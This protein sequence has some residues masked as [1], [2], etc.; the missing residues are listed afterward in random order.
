[1]LLKIYQE[2]LEVLYDHGEFEE[3]KRR[4]CQARAKISGNLSPDVR[5][6]F[7]YVLAGYYDYVLGGAYDAETA[8]ETQVVQLLLNTVNKAI[9]WLSLSGTDD[10]RILLGE[11]CRLKALVLIRSGLGKKKRFFAILEKVRK[12]I[13]RYAQPNSRLVRDYDMT[14]AW[15]HTY[16]DEDFQKTRASLFKAHEITGIIST[17]ELAK[18]DDQ[19]CPMA[20][21]MLEWRQYEDA[22]QYL[23]LSIAICGKHQEIA[24]YQRRQTELLGHLLQVYFT[25]GEYGKCQ[26]VIDK[27]D[28]KA[29]LI[30][31]VD[32]EDYVPMD[33]RETVTATIA[34]T[35]KNS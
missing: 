1:M 7:Y 33:T 3:A 22:E 10:A 21:I 11:C 4:I 27:L 5:G 8:E 35:R 31:T 13:D 28:E 26:A 23:R 6:R 15:Y 29:A 17:S 24:A 12:L 18:I 30:G 19:L 34:N 2:L 9:R 16:L 25:A 14:L 20:N 32:I